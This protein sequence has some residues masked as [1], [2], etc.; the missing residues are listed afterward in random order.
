MNPYF[1]YFSSSDSYDYYDN[2]IQ[3]DLDHDNKSVHR[4]VKSTIIYNILNPDTRRM[5]RKKV[6]VGFTNSYINSDSL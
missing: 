3:L 6:P 5:L 1:K 4:T 2:I